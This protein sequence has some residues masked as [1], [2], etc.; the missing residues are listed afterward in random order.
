MFWLEHGASVVIGRQTLFLRTVDTTHSSIE[1]TSPIIASA[2]GTVALRG[3]VVTV[4]PTSTTVNTAF[5]VLAVDRGDAIFLAPGPT[6]RFW[7]QAIEVG[8]PGDTQQPLVQFEAVIMVQYPA[9]I[10]N[11]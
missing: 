7:V 4:I 5:N 11:M 9:S 2:T 8:V 1:L 3:V 10:T 6:Q